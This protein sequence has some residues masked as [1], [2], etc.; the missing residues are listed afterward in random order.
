MRE[1]VWTRVS[2]DKS[3]RLQRMGPGGGGEHRSDLRSELGGRLRSF[4]KQAGRVC[5]SFL[6]IAASGTGATATASEAL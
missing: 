1:Q 4:A 3:L 6:R 2:V 5:A